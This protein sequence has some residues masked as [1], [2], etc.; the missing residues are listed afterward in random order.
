MIIITILRPH[1][2]ANYSALK[3]AISAI[4]K[5]NNNQEITGQL[6]QDVL[7][8]IISTIG[9]NAT[10]IGVA[11]PNTNP[12]TLDSNS[13]YIAATKGVYSNFGGYEITKSAVIFSNKSG[14]WAATQLDIASLD[15]VSENIASDMAYSGYPYIHLNRLYSVSSNWQTSTDNGFISSD[16]WDCAVIRIYKDS[17][18]L[19]IEG[20]TPGLIVYFDSL[21]IAD[22]VLGLGSSIPEGAKMCVVDFKKSDNPNGYKD[23][24]I[25][26]FGSGVDRE[27]LQT[28]NNALVGN[29]FSLEAQCIKANNGTVTATVTGLNA[30]EFLPISGK[31]DITIIGAWSYLVNNVAAY[32]FYDKNKKFISSN[33]EDIPVKSYT[34]P[35]EDIPEGAA[36]IRCTA[37]LLQQP[38]PEVKGVLSLATLM[39]EIASGVNREELQAS[40]AELLKAVGLSSY[41]SGDSI[42]GIEE[43]GYMKNDGSL[44]ITTDY[45]H[46]IYSVEG[47]KKYRVHIP[48]FYQSSIISLVQIKN[49]DGTVISNLIPL[50]NPGNREI[51]AILELPESASQLIVNWRKSIGSAPSVYEAALQA[52][53]IDKVLKKSI[54]EDCFKMADINGYWI[55]SS[56]IPVQNVSFHY[57]KFDVSDKSKEYRVTTGIGNN[58]ALTAVHYYDNEGNWLSSEYP[59]TGPTKIT[60]TLL[61]VPEKATYIYVN[62]NTANAPILTQT[63]LGEFYDLATLAD[64]NKDN[65]LMKVRIYALEPDTNSESYA[66]YIRT[67][68]NSTKDIIVLYY[69]NGN[70]IISPNAT[71]VGNNELADLELMTS[72]YLVSSHTDSTAPFFGSSLY[73]HLF[74]QHGYVIPRI[75][76]TLNMTS[77]EVGSVWKD[78]LERQYTIGNVASDIVYL[79]PV[80]TRGVGE[81]NDTRGWKT[82]NDAAITT[83]THVSGGSYSGSFIFAVTALSSTQLRPIMKHYNRHWLIDGVEINKAGD[84]WCDEF[85]V[86]ESQIGYDPATVNT[87]FPTP[88]LSDALEMARF[89]WSYNFKGANCAVNTTVAIMRKVECQSYGACQQQFFFDKGNYK[90]MFLIPKLKQ[91]S[92]IDPSKPFNSPSASSNGLYYFRDSSHLINVNDPVDRQ[93]GYLYDEGANDYLIGMAAGLSLVSGDTVKEKRIQNIPVNVNSGG[94]ERLGSFS[95]S[96][97]NK[98]YI[99]AINTA[100]FASDNY[101]FPNTYFKE[102]N[103]YVSYFDPSENK[104]QVY[105]Y[106]DGNSYVIYMHC[107]SAYNRLA[108]KLP[109]FMEGL[110]V[111]IVEKTDGAAL[112][113]DTIQNGN[114]FVTYTNAANYIVLKTR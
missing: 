36:Y 73:W 17:G 31:N 8:N 62:A 79:L 59:I 88:V 47:T 37:N 42:E 63:G 69:F 32:A 28:V 98:F 113:T 33:Q 43:E 6:L 75:S 86:S 5:T 81:G 64:E 55:N 16:N 70:T 49:E 57:A 18:K 72:A 107:Q 15:F 35:V 93:I 77:A 29:I 25:R 106:K 114:L 46:T 2:M 34:I 94:H 10:F 90:A 76:N 67:K 78:Q 45:V 84:Y 68:Y 44:L 91:Q 30:T 82:P 26:Q 66:F 108:V 87:W 104:G 109:D 112:L 14:E 40:E 19:E 41:K 4:I 38:N 101:N 100:L 52:D 20:A 21:E 97:I 102:I 89:T 50:D 1:S 110:K 53:N 103:Y 83:L 39:S 22:T 3:T 92:G 13:F 96:N 61:H 105:W 111:E 12:G 71:Y 56:G 11:T 54:I 27:E 48:P 9:A 74:A 7:N 58:S 51:D 24:R 80:I 65:K 85:K 60:N 23:L 99:A 95:P